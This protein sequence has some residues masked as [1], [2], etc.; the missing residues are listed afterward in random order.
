MQLTGLEQGLLYTASGIFVA[1]TMVAVRVVSGQ[2]EV[3]T[4]RPMIVAGTVVLTC[5]LLILA[6]RQR[7]IPVTTRAEVLFVAAWCLAIGAGLVDRR[8]SN[9]ILG[10]VTAPTM[11]ILLA[12]SVLLTLRSVAIE[13]ESMHPG[14]ILH[15][16]LAIL[17]LAALTFAAGTG[18]YYLWQIR[19]LKRRPA[20]ALSYR[21]PPLEV[22]DRLNFGSVAFGFPFL[23]LSVLGV[24]LF[25][26]RAGNVSEAWLRDPTVLVTL[27]GL[28][29]YVALFAA[30]GLL[31]WR[32]RRIAWLTVAG[33]VIIVVG[34]VIASFCTSGGVMHTS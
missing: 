5:L 33:F 34:L 9:P 11:A 7:G 8:A 31:G 28:L 10:V 16:L 12:F 14:V 19:E 4:L 2:R 15:I 27:G 13:T 6:I 22:L 32:G 24:W 20:L 18:A 1:A 17:G 30:R 29:V 23:A 3:R 26:A 25:S 21:V